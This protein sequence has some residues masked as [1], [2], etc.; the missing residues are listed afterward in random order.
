[1]AIP[2]IS[3]YELP[4][5][6]SFP[7][8]KV[9]WKIDSDKAVLL[10][11]DMQEYFV[12]FFDT[13][14]SPVPALV[15]NI[16]N[17]K[18]AAKAAGI[19]VIYT[20]QP[21]N[22]DLEERALLTDFW[23]PGLKQDTAILDELA[24]VEDDIQYTKWRYSAFK[25]SP[26][27]AFLKDEGRDQLIICGIYGHIGV[28]ATALDAFMM[29]VKPFVIGDAIA[30]FSLAEHK[31]TLD[32]VTGRCGAVKHLAQAVAEI[33]ASTQTTNVLTL[34]SM[35]QDVADILELELDEVDINENLI[36]LGLDSIRAMALIEKWRKQ[37][38]KIEFAELVKQVTL[39]QW[40]QMIEPMTMSA[41]SAA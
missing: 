6:A 21:A 39:A 5:I 24:P 25:K 19:P 2:R 18:A 33:S 34:V 23:G 1:M 27:R 11:H 38:V 13:Q 37:G 32:Y 7:D 31:S 20:A 26:L 10:I 41:D 15:Q 29:D 30:D 14:L 36:F 8:N 17:L 12:N 3:H 9:G 40:W 16:A 28:Q 35:Q 4:D 22:Q